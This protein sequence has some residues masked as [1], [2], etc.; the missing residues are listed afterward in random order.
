MSPEVLFL[1]EPSNI[2]ELFCIYL[3]W[4][5]LLDLEEKPVFAFL[6]LW[7]VFVYQAGTCLLYFLNPG[8]ETIHV[9]FGS[10]KFTK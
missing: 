8:P 3:L 2:V 1:N 9:Q 7:T 10:F 4:A 6:P 5:F